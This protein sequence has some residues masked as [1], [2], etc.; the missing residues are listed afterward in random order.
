MESEW[1]NFLSITRN[2]WVFLLHQQIAKPFTHCSIIS[3]CIYSKC[4]TF[5]FFTL[6]VQQSNKTQNKKPLYTKTMA[7]QR[8]WVHS[9]FILESADGRCRCWFLVCYSYI[10]FGLRFAFCLSATT[11]LWF[12]SPDFTKCRAYCRR[13]ENIKEVEKEQKE[14][15]N[16]KKTVSFLQTKVSGTDLVSFSA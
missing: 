5:F 8:R 12:Q 1:F 10:L 14:E 9:A 6:G 15:N 7:Y 11:F 13:N 16:Y 2:T 4:L 3:T